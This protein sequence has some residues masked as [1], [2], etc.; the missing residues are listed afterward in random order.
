ME[1]KTMKG[2]GGGQ[3]KQLV[4][5]INFIRYAENDERIH[6]ITFMDGEYVNMLFRSQQPKI[7]RQYADIV[8]CLKSNPGNYF[9]NTAGFVRPM[10]ILNS[11]QVGR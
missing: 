8:N 4:E 9:V 11:A 2:S 3:D 10:E 5:V 6:Y 1:M 7:R